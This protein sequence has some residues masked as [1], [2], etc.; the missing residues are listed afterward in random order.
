MWWTCGRGP[1]V[2]QSPAAVLSPGHLRQRCTTIESMTWPQ[3]VS[4]DG[5]SRVTR[6]VCI[7]MRVLAPDRLLQ[8][9]AGTVT[10]THSP[11]TGTPQKYRT[12]GTPRGPARC[13]ERLSR[14]VE[15]PPVS[16]NPIALTMAQS[17]TE[18]VGVGTGRYWRQ[19]IYHTILTVDGHDGVCTCRRRRPRKRGVAVHQTRQCPYT[20]PTPAHVCRARRHQ[21][22]RRLRAIRVGGHGCARGGVRSAKGAHPCAAPPPRPVPSA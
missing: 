1:L 22:R 12:P 13:A 21:P 3:L 15:Q 17:D 19:H 2:A 5:V 4:L 11:M 9:D 6:S 7:T 8:Q 16:P 20:A 18:P 10:G 14:R